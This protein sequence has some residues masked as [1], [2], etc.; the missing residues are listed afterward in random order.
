MLVMSIIYLF[1]L[2]TGKKPLPMM[3]MQMTLRVC[4]M[5]ENNNAKRN[6]KLINCHENRLNK[7][8]HGSLTCW[9]IIYRDYFILL[10]DKQNTMFTAPPC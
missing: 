1:C 8:G 7:L 10:T 4:C 2:L 3:G 6:N 9:G 5:A